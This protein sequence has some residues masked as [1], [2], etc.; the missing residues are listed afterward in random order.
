VSLTI[1]GAGLAG[2]IAA[3][4]WPQ[5]RVIESSSSLNRGGHKALLRFRSDAV[6]R[7]TGIDFKKVTVRKGIWLDD[8][9]V[10]PNVR[11]ANM[12]AQK[13]AGSLLGD[14][15]IWNLDPVERFIAPESLYED[16]I[17]NVGARVSWDTEFDFKN[18]TPPIVNTAPLSLVLLRLFGVEKSVAL[19]ELQR[20]PI[21][22]ARYRVKDA[23]VYQTVYFPEPEMRV[24]R[25]SI[26]GS[27]L[28]VECM[29]TGA[30][31]RAMPEG[32]VDYDEMQTV[33]EA[34]GL[35]R[36]FVE[37]IEV[38]K[39]KYGK[40]VPLPDAERKAWLHALTAQHG[41]FSLGRFATWRNILLD[42]V[43]QDITVLRRLMKASNYERA[44]FAA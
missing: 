41:I 42:D 23:D 36:M 39:Q 11:A 19:P 1:V 34:F 10:Q 5:A 16:L 3:H 20:A 44:I 32:F 43:V 26:T 31:F 28:I 27:L 38:V 33:L 15:S 13:V 17:A 30:S 14:R 22:V 6:A 12:Y 2:L 4:A 8:Q 24:Y 21:R 37:P 40:I 9:F 35:D 18:F 29:E 25:A 7:L